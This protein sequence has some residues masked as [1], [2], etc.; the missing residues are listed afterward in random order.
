MGL[1]DSL[2]GQ[3]GR[4]KT[5]VLASLQQA[6]RMRRVVLEARC[7]MLLAR[8]ELAAGRAK[9]AVQG[10]AGILPEAD[11]TLG[12]ELRAQIH[13][14]RGQALARAGDRAAAATEAA[15]AR[16]LVAQL[17]QLIPQSHRK[18]LM[19]RPDIRLISGG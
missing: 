16:T 13:Y 3:P 1:I 15:T 17:E 14:W 12:P 6:R 5:L 4:G 7:R 9:E 2:R 10:L 11:A 18:A 19:S 8:I